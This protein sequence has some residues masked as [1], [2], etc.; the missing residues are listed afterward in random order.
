MGN[1]EEQ[2]ENKGEQKEQGRG[3]QRTLAR[4][5]GLKRIEGREQMRSNL[6]LSPTQPAA[7]RGS[8]ELFPL[9]FLKNKSRLICP[10][11]SVLGLRSFLPTL[12]AP[13]STIG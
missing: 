3:C 9:V 7:C 10:W 13:D 6:F 8:P 11:S 5:R 12:I 2:R 1:W 4:I